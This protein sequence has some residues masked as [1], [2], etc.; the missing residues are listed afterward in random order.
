M[1]QETAQQMTQQEK[2]N[3]FAKLHVKG[4]PLVLT[5]IWDA[6]SA[7]VVEAGGAKALATG[8]HSVAAA[9]GFED[10]ER[11]PLELVLA[12]LKRIVAS[13]TLPVSLDVESGYGESA[14][15]VAATVEEVIKA[16]AVGIN[17]EDQI[18]RGEG[19]YSIQ[20]QSERIAAVRKVADM[21]GVPLFIN[22]RTDVYLQTKPE[23]HGEAHLEEAL[24]RAQA[25]A[26]AGASGFFAPG[27]LEAQAIK[28]LCD[29]SPLPVNIMLTNDTPNVQQLAALG[30]A[31]ISLGPGP[32]RRVV[33]TLRQE[34]LGIA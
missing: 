5:N 16:G 24:S 20:A 25:Y 15:E 32:Y 8:S 10:G 31:R 6:G 2:A 33:D 27:L 29:A 21:L 28:T 19:R 23:A 12:N 30:V 18:I 7:R 9:H 11:L 3:L 4:K 26:D 14:E 34:G 13:A 17:L 22:A 1:T